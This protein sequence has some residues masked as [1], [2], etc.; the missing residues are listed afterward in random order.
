MT[1]VQRPEVR[2]VSLASCLA[3]GALELRAG[4][5]R[6]V[7]FL[8]QGDLVLTHSNLKGDSEQAIRLRYPD[9][10]A[11]MLSQLQAASRLAGVL[12]VEQD[13]TMQ[14]HAGTTAPQRMNLDLVR[15][16]LRALHGGLD[17][18]Q[19]AELLSESG[20]GAPAFSPDQ[21]FRFESCD[22]EPET[23]QWLAALDGAVSLD[24][25][26]NACPGGSRQASRMLLIASWF[27]ALSVD[28]E[29]VSDQ[30][31]V[32]DDDAIVAVQS[33]VSRIAA[34]DTHFQVL[35]PEWDAPS[36]EFR[37][38][39]FGLA[40]LLHPDRLGSF[41]TELRLEAERAFDQARQA[42]EV[43]GDADSRRAYTDHVIHGKKTEEEIAR[44]EMEAIFA[45]ESDFKRGLVAFNAGQIRVAQRAFDAAVRQ[46]PGEPEYKM[47]LGYTNFRVNRTTNNEAAERGRQMLMDV[48]DGM[49]ERLAAAGDKPPPRLTD[50]SSRSWMLMGR[51]YRDQAD[52]ASGEEATQY[53]AAAKRCFFQA[54][55]VNPANSDAQRELKR[56]KA[57]RERE[58]TGFF[59]GLFGRSKKK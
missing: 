24:D 41:P 57:E 38:A 34:A 31:A 33:A 4:K 19:V 42:W 9:V 56:M 2:L 50:L 10:D 11:Q 29:A 52:G 1:T 54:L 20:V 43:V 28:A 46:D 5:K 23:L 30:E 47:Y 55:R 40:R 58:S 22:L 12:R 37:T 8:D 45:A 21:M 49:K 14:W 17:D 32:L 18:E 16:L 51:V 53:K 44:E 3:T 59:A 35:G 36:D 27:G 6:W 48:V 25:V 15:E 39:F 7:L 13:L 26:L